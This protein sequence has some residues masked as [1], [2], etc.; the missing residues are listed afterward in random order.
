M[1]F[2][3]ESRFGGQ[4][5]LRVE[6]IMRQEMSAQAGGQAL[7][8]RLRS[9]GLG[10]RKTVALDDYRRFQ[11][12]D[13]SLT[14]ESRAR[15]ENWYDKVYEPFRKEHGYNAKQATEALNKIR[16]G[17]IETEEE[18]IEAGGYAEKYESEFG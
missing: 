5:I 8:E 9:Q 18:A 1:P 14:P 6:T 15:A 7:Y 11:A 12:V 10:Y 13:R 16:E 17:S 4:D 2:F 3:Y